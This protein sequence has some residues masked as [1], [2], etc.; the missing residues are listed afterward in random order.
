MVSPLKHFGPA[1]AFVGEWF[2]LIMMLES[3]QMVR[4]HVHGIWADENKPA[5]P[6]SD[7]PGTGGSGSGRISGAFKDISTFS[8][9]ASV[10]S[11]VTNIWF[12]NVGDCLHESRL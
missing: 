11:K 3:G 10:A 5:S 6:G 1:E 7:R 9:A 12:V 4:S 2:K 8:S